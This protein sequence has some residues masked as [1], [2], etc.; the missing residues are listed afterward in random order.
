M[1]TR[2]LQHLIGFAVW[3]TYLGAGVAVAATNGYLD[4]LSSAR[5][6]ATAVGAVLLWPFVFLE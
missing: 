4:G 5:A 1:R 2:L 3:A 6:L